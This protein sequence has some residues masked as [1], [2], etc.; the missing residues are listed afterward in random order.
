[1]YEKDEVHSTDQWK[2]CLHNALH[3][4]LTFY[5]GMLYIKLY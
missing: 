5:K 4:N 1:M 3:I 2:T